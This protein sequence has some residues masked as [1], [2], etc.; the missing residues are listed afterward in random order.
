MIDD[1]L[2]RNEFV[3]R[4]VQST[5]RSVD[6]IIPVIHTNGLWEQNLKSIY[7][8]IPIRRLLI[9]DGGCIDDSIAIVRRFP[10]VTVLVVVSDSK[11]IGLVHM[12]DLLRAGL[13]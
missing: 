5:D 11:P 12:H 3:D 9:S 13:R 7:R 2:R 1:I 4:F 6:V 8:E 10:R